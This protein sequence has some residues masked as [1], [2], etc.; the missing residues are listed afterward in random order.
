MQKGTGR[1]EVKPQRSKN[2]SPP[3]FANSRSSPGKRRA[4][5]LQQELDR[6]GAGRLKRGLKR[7]SKGKKRCEEG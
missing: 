1:A 2:G 4:R 5:G 6:Q 7:G 3:S